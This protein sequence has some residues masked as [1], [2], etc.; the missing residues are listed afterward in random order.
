M[1][2]NIISQGFSVPM[3]ADTSEITPNTDFDVVLED[4]GVATIRFMY[5]EDREATTDYYQ[6]RITDEKTWDKVWEN[7]GEGKM[8]YND[9]TKAQS[10]MEA[11]VTDALNWLGADKE[12]VLDKTLFT[13]LK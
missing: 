10:S 2:Y 6:S 8:Y 4:G 13:H 3:N 1:K 11:L 9:W 7:L 5:E 12:R